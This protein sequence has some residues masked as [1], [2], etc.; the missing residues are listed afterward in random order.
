MSDAFAYPRIMLKIMLAYI[1]AHAYPSVNLQ[2]KTASILGMYQLNTVD[3][4]Y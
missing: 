3:P 1:W 4:G 2:I